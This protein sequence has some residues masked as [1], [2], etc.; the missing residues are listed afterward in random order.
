MSAD[1]APAEEFKNS[2]GNNSAN[3]PAIVTELKAALTALTSNV[4]MPISP[5][6]R[7]SPWNVLDDRQILFV[8]VLEEDWLKHRQD[9]NLAVRALVG[10]DREHAGLDLC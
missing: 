9:P 1:R 2:I 6:S 4:T 5:N 7:T 3:L 10:E 8:V